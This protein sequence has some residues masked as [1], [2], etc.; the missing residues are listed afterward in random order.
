MIQERIGLRI[1]V[2]KSLLYE[3]KKKC[4]R[5]KMRKYILFVLLIT[6]CASVPKEEKV[7]S[8][9][10]VIDLIQKAQESFEINNYRAA[11]KWYEIILHRFG[12][13]KSVRVEA[14]YELAHILVKQKKWKD[15]YHHLK[16]IIELY[17]TKDGM[18]LPQEFYKLAKMDYEKVLK[19]L[20]SSYI[21]S[22]ARKKM[23]KEEVQERNQKAISE[24]S[25][26]GNSNSEDS[27][28]DAISLEEASDDAEKESL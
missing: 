19:K 26:N 4:E 20:S 22:V 7:P 21:E 3:I 12:D 10:E 27:T 11:K 18:R 14:E 9:M 5:R 15:A 16:P 13:D 8:D 25:D 28:S 2:W 17:E 1:D 24:T 23:E 6:S